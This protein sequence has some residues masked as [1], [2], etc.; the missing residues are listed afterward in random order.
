MTCGV[1]T[2]Y[3]NRSCVADKQHKDDCDVEAS[4]EAK[5]CNMADCPGVNVTAATFCARG[6]HDTRH[7]F[8]D[9]FWVLV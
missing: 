2:E 7:I 8:C 9:H 6:T 5:K 4:F 1:G 3:R